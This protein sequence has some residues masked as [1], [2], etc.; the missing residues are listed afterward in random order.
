MKTLRIRRAFTLVELLVVV[1]I[2]GILSSL[3]TV[4]VMSAVQAAKRSRVAMEMHQ[5]SLALETYKNK[6]GEYP[7]DLYDVNA[8][9]RH[10]KKRWPRFDLYHDPNDINISNGVT[11][12]LLQYRSLMNAVCNV[13]RNQDKLAM[14]NNYDGYS[15]TNATLF[16]DNSSS[17]T[18]EASYIGA[19]PFWLGGFPNQDGKFSGFSADPEAPLG[20]EW[21]NSVNPPVVIRINNGDYRASASWQYNDIMLSTQDK[22]SVFY[23]MIIGKNIMLVTTAVDGSKPAITFP[24]LVNRDATVNKDGTTPVPYIYFKSTS[25]NG[26]KTAYAH[27]SGT[28]IYMSKGYKFSVIFNNTPYAALGIITAYAQ[29]N[30]DA[31][32]PP[33]VWQESERFQLIH[34]GLDGIFGNGSDRLD[35]AAIQL[36]TSATPTLNMSGFR[37]TDTNITTNDIGQ[38]DFD[39]ITNFSDYQ[40]IKSILP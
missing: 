35:S 29:S 37:S 39:N 24:A 18:R 28:N 1:V 27:L 5:I 36:T 26:G 23:E 9:I 38:Q 6:F 4:G 17:I 10:M 16:M 22:D 34:P 8:V 33:L 15:F 40:Q 21:N 20:K 2:I 3:V 32:N 30:A 11:K 19:L 13:Y 12:E 31:P 14:L 7:P 25:S